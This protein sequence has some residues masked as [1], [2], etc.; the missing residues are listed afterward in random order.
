M[1]KW[2][3]GARS[4][5]T[6][7]ILA[8][9]L[10]AAIIR[11]WNFG[12][13][14]YQHWDEYYFLSGAN[15]VSRFWP[16]G[17]GSITWV[18]GPL[19]PYTDGTLFHFLGVNSWM[20]LAVSAVYG[21][22]SV[23]ALYFLGSRLFGRA[24]GLIAAALFATAGFS[25]M[26][27]RMA[28]ADATFNFWLIASVLFIWLG[29]ER[30][31]IAYYVLAGICSGLLLNTKFNGIFPLLLVVS[32]LVVELLIDW[33]KGRGKSAPKLSDYRVRVIGTALMV[34]LATAM[35]LPFLIKIA[36]FP[37]LH[38]VLEHERSF[39]PQSLIKTSPKIL[40]WYYWLFTSPATVLA[41]IAGIAFA[42]FRFTRA[43][44][45]MLIYTA[46]WFV[47]LMLFA[48]YPREALSLLPAVAIWAARALAEIWK[49]VL[50]R[51]PG[52]RFAAPAAAAACTSVVLISQFIPLPHMLSL[53]TQGYADA[54]V[55]ATRYQAAG[56][57]IFARTQAVAFLYA[58][59]E[60]SLRS[61]PSVA[62][63]LNQ[64]GSAAVLVTDQTLLWYPVL[65]T[66]FEM[67]RD[68]LT[69][70]NRVPNPQFD[71]VLLQPATEEKLQQLSDPPD[72]DRYITFW[73]VTG[74]LLYP[75]GWPQ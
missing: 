29:F 31:R 5:N 21:T 19:V 61:D 8:V 16:R 67:N 37:G 65:Q 70:M 4:W 40:L 27:S 43:D 48:P 47:A 71:E 33:I 24:V 11:L 54:G 34:A 35:F 36:H 58:K 66:F 3:Q 73:R 68:R 28:I 15:A 60:F 14:G 12:E 46:G 63:A 9:V 69:V 10:V 13:L 50:S 45:L 51:R 52:T 2:V 38:A 22:L 41:A 18:I 62:R 39:G 74:T 30:K 25:V 49:L 64:K 42:L 57:S 26:F 56:D 1:N 17:F 53:R 59:G 72:A 44:R 23:V 75:P 20:P 7:L 55:I 32:W 6:F